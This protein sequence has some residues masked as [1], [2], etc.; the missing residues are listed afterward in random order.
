M[1]LSTETRRPRETR[2]QRRRRL[3]K[4]AAR[5]QRNRIR[6]L[7]RLLTDFRARCLELVRESKMTPEALALLFP[8]VIR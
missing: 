8:P 4:A 3:R 2:A 6:K 7:E 5:R 1:L